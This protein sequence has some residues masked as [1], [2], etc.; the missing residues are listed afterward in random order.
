MPNTKPTLYYIHDPMCSWC[1]AFHRTW[2]KVQQQINGQINIKYI[3]GGLAEDSHEVMP[4]S[5]QTDIAGYWK[6][7]QKKV[8]GTKFNFDFWKKNK[9]RRSTYPACRAVLAAK[10]LKPSSEQTMILGI[11]EA[12][13]LSAKN[14]SDI[15]VLA[16]VAQSNNIDKD[17]FLKAIKSKEIQNQLENEISFSKSIFAQGFPSLILFKGGEYKQ[18]QIDYNSEN[19]IIKQLQIYIK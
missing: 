12:Y 1:W 11:Q 6:V 2:Q 16:E 19:F 5:M 7:I 10:S 8:P 3:V 9:P 17:K 14:P 4:Q 15:E 13:Y 18:I